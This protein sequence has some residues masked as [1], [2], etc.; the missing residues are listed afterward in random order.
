MEGTVKELSRQ[1]QRR[2]TLNYYKLLRVAVS[3]VKYMVNGKFN[4][5]LSGRIME[6]VLRK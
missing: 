3:A 5:I 4:I 2:H 6:G 1:E